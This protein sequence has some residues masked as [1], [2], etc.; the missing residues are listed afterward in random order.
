M[1]PEQFLATLRSQP[2]QPVYLFI[3]LLSNGVMA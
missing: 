1:T 2:P 3:G